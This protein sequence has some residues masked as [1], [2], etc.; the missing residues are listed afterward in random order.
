MDEIARQM[1]LLKLYLAW[2]RV[3][4]Q[5]FLERRKPAVRAERDAP[6][7]AELDDER[8]RVGHC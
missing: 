8:L 3:K 6:A 2:S 4:S 7:A 1:A 5:S